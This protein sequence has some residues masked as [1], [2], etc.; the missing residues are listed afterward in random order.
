MDQSPRRSLQYDLMH[1]LKKWSSIIKESSQISC[2]KPYELIGLYTNSYP[3]YAI[4]VNL[5]RRGSSTPRSADS[6]SNGHGLRLAELKTL[7][8]NGLSVQQNLRTLSIENVQRTQQTISAL[9]F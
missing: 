2:M 3:G 1:D 9:F 4:P 8:E 5:W 6:F 7:E